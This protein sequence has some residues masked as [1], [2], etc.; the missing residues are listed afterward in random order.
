MT[1]K[2]NQPDRHDIE[3]GQN[4]EFIESLYEKYS[5]YKEFVNEGSILTEIEKNVI[6]FITENYQDINLMENVVKKF[7]MVY[8]DLPEFLKTNRDIALFA[9]NLENLKHIPKSLM[10][11]EVFST[12]LFWRN[13]VLVSHES[14]NKYITDKDKLLENIA[15]DQYYASNIPDA[16]A[17]DRNFWLQVMAANGMAV[18]FLPSKFWHDKEIAIAA[19]KENCWAIKHLSTIFKSDSDVIKLAINQDEEMVCYVNPE[20]FES[21]PEL[22]TRKDLLVKYGTQYG[23]WN[24]KD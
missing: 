6:D 15:R 23:T 21:D 3:S 4:L 18:R 10:D 24:F 11:D 13:P 19:V 22:F 9:V 8:K 16:W 1:T 7:P 17:S 14:I 2:N 5:A 20:T 12:T